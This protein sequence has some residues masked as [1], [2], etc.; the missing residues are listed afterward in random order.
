MGQLFASTVCLQK[1]RPHG[2]IMPRS[3]LVVSPEL[4]GDVLACLLRVAVD[5]AA[6]ASESHLD[7]S[8]DLDEEVL[9]FGPDLVLEVFTI[10]GSGEDDG[11]TH[12][13]VFHYVLLD[14]IVGG[15]GE[16]DEGDVGKILFEA[17]HLLVVGTC[18]G[19][20]SQQDHQLRGKEITYESRDPKS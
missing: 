16:G 20:P 13:K 17:A 8:G 18:A 11:R 19:I 6:F 10:E 2:M 5:D 4:V 15:G 1:A 12:A 14:A 7:E 3:N 9:A